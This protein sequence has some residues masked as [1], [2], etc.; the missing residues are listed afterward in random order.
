M[1]ENK[2]TQ[3][4]NGFDY[5]QRPQQRGNA[6]A[7]RMT[8]REVPIGAA[9]RADAKEMIHQWLDGEVSETAARRADAAQV[10]FWSRVNAE[11]EQRRRMTTPSHVMDA[12]MESLP[13]R[14][15]EKSVVR[16]V[17]DARLALTPLQAAAAAAGFTALGV[18]IGRLIGR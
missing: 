14:T 1:L 10:E 11:T 8:D 17:D 7:G 12:I 3:G 5:P 4:D 6:D 13:A 9:P 18:V 15:P 16:F 2:D